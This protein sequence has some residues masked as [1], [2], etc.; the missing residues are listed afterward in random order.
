MDRAEIEDIA[1]RVLDAAFEVHR[2]LGPGLLESTYEIAICYELSRMGISFERQREMPVD[3]KGTR[4]D[5]GYRIDLLVANEVLVELKAIEGL[6]PIHEAQL[7][8]YL[9]L[10]NKR[11]GL[12]INFNVR[13]LKHGI[14]RLVNGLPDQIPL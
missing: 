9:K 10:A 5:C 3:Y 4:L 13:L 14:K 11:L 2:H 8:T 6:Q 12:L 7:L 1:A